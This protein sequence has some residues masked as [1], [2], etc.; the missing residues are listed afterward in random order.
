MKK[1]NLEMLLKGLEIMK[2]AIVAELGEET[3]TDAKVVNIEE[4][5]EKKE[6]KKSNKKQEKILSEEEVAEA[7]EAMEVETDN[8]AEELNKMSLKDLKDKA[9]EL[10]V[11]V[12]GSKSAIIGRILEAMDAEDEDD[13]EVIEEEV[14]ET[15]E[16]VEEEDETVG[17]EVETVDL[18]EA[19]KDYTVEELAEML[20]EAGISTK[21]KK[22]ALIAKVIKAVEEGKIEFETDEDD[23]EVEED[24]VVE[25]T[26][27]DEVE[28]EDVDVELEDILEEVPLKEVKAICKELGIKVTM[29]DKKPSLI[30]KLNDFEDTDALIQLLIDKE[31]IETSDFEGEDDEESDELVIEGSEER[32]EAV[33]ELYNSTIEEIEN[34]E[35]TID[36]IRE[37]F[38]E[39]YDG[40]KAKLKKLDAMEDEELATEYAEMVANCIDDDG[41]EVEFNT[42]Y[43]VGDKPYCCGKPMKHVEGNTYVCVVDGDEV[44][45]D[46]EE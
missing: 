33:K 6:A 27:E 4:A 42:P 45:L 8:L 11:A 43:L 19:L 36:E 17:D 16:E 46:D 38:T 23:E 31:I 25:D 24:E 13:E 37:F 29:K 3:V 1:S 39:L 41:D 14:I 26:T 7:T 5:K 2:E 32:Q 21:G 35:I 34:E 10:G 12:R 22:Q 40:D 44:E 28:A 9:K 30:D 18:E 15:D 20:A